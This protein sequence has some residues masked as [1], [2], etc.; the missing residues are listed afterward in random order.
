MWAMQGKNLDKEV[1]LPTSLAL[2]W[3]MQ[4]QNLEKDVAQV[5]S[6]FGGPCR[7]KI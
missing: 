7:A 5:D 4:G 1:A 6:P 3:A 2:L